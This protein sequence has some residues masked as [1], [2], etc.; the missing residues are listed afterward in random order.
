MSRQTIS[1]AIVVFN[2]EKNN[3]LYMQKVKVAFGLKKI[4]KNIEVYD[5]SHISGYFAVGVMISFNKDGFAK[6]NYRKYNSG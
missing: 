2:E 5:I 3:L 4:P 1:C 6:N